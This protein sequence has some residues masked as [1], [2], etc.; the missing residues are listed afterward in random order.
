MNNIP[1]KHQIDAFGGEI[2]KQLHFK[3]IKALK[4]A[5][6]KAQYFFVTCDK[7]I[8]IDN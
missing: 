1:Q 5:M 6:A 4:V 7:V 8:S 2:G 3:V